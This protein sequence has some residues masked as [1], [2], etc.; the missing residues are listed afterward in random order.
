M[1]FKQVVFMCCVAY[2]LAQCV[3]VNVREIPTVAISLKHSPRRE[4]LEKHMHNINMPFRYFDAFEAK[5]FDDTE[6]PR[7]LKRRINNHLYTFLN[8]NE[9]A[10]VAVAM[11]HIHVWEQYQNYSAV[12]VLEDDVQLKGNLDLPIYYTSDTILVTLLFNANSAGPLLGYQCGM[13]LRDYWFGLAG[14]IITQNG[15]QRMLHYLQQQNINDGIDSCVKY[16]KTSSRNIVL[17]KKQQ[18]WVDHG[19]VILESDKIPP[20]ADSERVRYNL[21]ARAHKKF[22]LEM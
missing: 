13:E 20:G 19:P 15:M 4:K 18:L 10:D 1:S 2:I 21:R 22:K 3:P 6:N 12:L 11:S 14:Y 7:V 9:P 17:S 5:L 16:F 8:Q